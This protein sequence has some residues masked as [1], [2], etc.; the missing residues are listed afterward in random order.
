MI[1]PSIALRQT[2]LGLSHSATVR[3]VV[4]KLLHPPTVKF[5]ELAAQPGGDTYAD[6]MRE[7]FDLGSEVKK[8]SVHE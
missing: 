4:D 1:D 8:G 2:L 3:R 7:L 6:I 5:K